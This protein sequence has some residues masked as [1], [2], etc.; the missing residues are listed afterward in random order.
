VWALERLHK[1]NEIVSTLV[2]A[3]STRG[4]CRRPG[5]W[6]R[7]RLRL[8]DTQV[9]TPRSCKNLNEIHDYPWAR[10]LQAACVNY[11]AR[12]GSERLGN[13]YDMA[14][15][16]GRKHLRFQLLQRKVFRV[17]PDG[18]APALGDGSPIHGCILR[19]RLARPTS[20]PLGRLYR[21]ERMAQKPLI[22]ARSGTGLPWGR[23]AI[24]TWPS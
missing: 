16:C 17:Q 15:E 7:P 10:R 12:R 6:M 11:A 14:S 23:T 20:P 9:A 3:P 5:A 4:A 8:V 22:T 13:T 18:S 2:K 19:P 21:R 1:K 24:W